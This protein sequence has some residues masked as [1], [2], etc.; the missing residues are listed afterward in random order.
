MVESGGV[1]VNNEMMI[2]VIDLIFMGMLWPT[3]YRLWK[4]KDSVG[5]SLWTSIPTSLMLAAMIPL[6]WPISVPIALAHIPGS[7]CWAIIAIGTWRYR[8]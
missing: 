2:V 6:F 5:H 3:V 8:K 4:A 1:T 7:V